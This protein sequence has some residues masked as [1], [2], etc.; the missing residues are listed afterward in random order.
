MNKM[1]FTKVYKD[2]ID[3]F[4]PETDDPR[5]RYLKRTWIFPNHIDI[6]I[7]FTKALA[8]KYH[9]DIE[10][11]VLGSFLHDAG[12]A[13]KRERA[14]SVGHEERSVEYA[15]K[16][17][18]NYGYNQ[19]IINAVVGCIRATEI[20]RSP[21]TIE[22]KVVRTTDALAHILS[23]HYFAKVSFSSDWES[24]IKFLEKKIKMDWQRISFDNER[25]RVRPIYEYLNQII[26]QYKGK[27]IVLR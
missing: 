21:K 18:P 4:P 16:F 25:E 9:A 6:G 11:C 15:R 22:E 2:L 27:S 1:K 13:Y 5:F 7:K 26:K 24:G 8:K 12:L 14:D 10:I 3:I 17:L 19:N 20:E 23:I